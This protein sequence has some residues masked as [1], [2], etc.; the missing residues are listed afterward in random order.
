VDKGQDIKLSCGAYE[1][2]LIPLIS[3]SMAAKNNSAN[4]NK[5]NI[6]TALVPKIFFPD[7]VNII[8]TATHKITHKIPSQYDQDNPFLLKTLIAGK[9][10]SN[11]TAYANNV[12]IN[13]TIFR[14]IQ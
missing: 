13:F 3:A 12:S 4:I 1:D 9:R 6:M 10:S 8:N 14:M 2:T 7:K 5:N 11:I